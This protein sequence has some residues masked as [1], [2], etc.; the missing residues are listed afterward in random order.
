[1]GG[2]WSRVVWM[3][4]DLKERVKDFIPKEVADKIATEKDT[5]TIDDLRKFLEARD[6]PVIERWKA[7]PV[8]A[9]VPADAAEPVP[10]GPAAEV[11]IPTASGFTI[12]L[13]NAKI[14]AEKVI[15]RRRKKKE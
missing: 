14:H 13:K 15:I 11:A 12:V 8:A 3:P 2:G 5:G 10:A 1:M 9:A 4:A 7:A 6:H